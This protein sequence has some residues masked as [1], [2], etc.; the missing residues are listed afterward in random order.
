MLLSRRTFI[1][2]LLA[3]AASG[4]A[5]CAFA[6]A[7]EA[8][9]TMPLS[10]LLVIGS[11]DSVCVID[12]KT[13]NLLHKCELG[14]PPH[15]ILRSPKE[16]HKVWL[17]Q[18]YATYVQTKKSNATSTIFKT[19]AFDL[20][21]GKVT[22]EIHAAAGSEYRGHA[23]FAAD[24]KTIF[25][26]RLDVAKAEGF[27]TGYDTASNDSKVVSDIALGKTGL[28]ECRLAADKQTAY[29]A[30]TGAINVEPYAEKPN[31]KRFSSG[32][33]TLVDLAGGKIRSRIDITDN[34]YYIGHFHVLGNGHILAT[35]STDNNSGRSGAVLWGHVDKSTFSTI[36]IP[37]ERQVKRSEKFDVAVHEKHQVAAVND[38]VLLEIYLIDTQTGKYLE[39][40]PIDAF[41]VCYDPYSEAFVVNGQRITMV[42]RHLTHLAG[43]PGLSRLMGPFKGSHS[44]II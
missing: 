19:V 14:F 28:H 37:Q 23:L 29:V 34:T 11:Q 43:A 33:L 39:K 20:R 2:S 6:K 32:G 8:E 26:T 24:G 3:F 17:V 12:M 4:A 30:T 5:P 22:N 9:H 36:D 13:G 15:A 27:L 42:D 41:G 35:S 38:N 31:Y 1:R 10:Q 18:R 40:I 21:S 16:S 44:L 25:I 7:L